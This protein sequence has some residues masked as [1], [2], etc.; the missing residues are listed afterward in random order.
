MAEDRGALGPLRNTR[1]PPFPSTGGASAPN[2]P[3]SSWSRHR[4]EPAAR[5]PTHRPLA[6]EPDAWRASS[7]PPPPKEWMP[8]C[9]D[10][11]L[12]S[13]SAALQRR[14]LVRLS[15]LLVDRVRIGPKSQLAKRLATCWRSLLK[16]EPTKISL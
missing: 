15:T 11:G 8:H 1:Q 13:S 9:R 4:A 6:A 7:L 14:L 5:P 3:W 16:L 2:V 10:A 12:G